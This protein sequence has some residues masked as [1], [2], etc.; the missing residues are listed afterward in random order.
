MDLKTKIELVICLML[1][2][3]G[4]LFLTI[5]LREWRSTWHIVQGGNHTQGMV[6]E[7]A[8]RP[9]KPGENLTPNSFAPVVLFVTDKGEQRKY[10]STLYTALP[11]YQIGQAVELWYLP[12]QPEKATMQAG[13]AWVLPLVF[14]IFGI[15]M[16]LIGYPWLISIIR[17]QL[18]R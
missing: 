15:V 14:G 13:D 4:T 3:A 18:L 10:Y 7:M 16:C 9:R 8:R 12:D 5:A 17:Q 6:V 2:L 11:T 1:C